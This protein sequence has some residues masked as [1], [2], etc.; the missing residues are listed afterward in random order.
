LTSWQWPALGDFAANAV[1]F[2]FGRF[3][4]VLLYFPTFF[5]CGLWM[6]RADR[7][8]A[9]WLGAAVASCVALQL[10]LPH[11][12]FGGTHALGN[13]LF[14]LLP[15]AL[16][17]VDVVAW[18]PW[19]VALSVA[20]LVLAVPLM[21]SPVYFSLY[22]GR[23]MLEAPY[24]WF[25]LEWRQATSLAF[26]YTFPGLLA[27]TRNQFEWESSGGVWTVGGKRAEFVLVRPTPGPTVVGL[28]SLLPAARVSDG[29]TTRDVHFSPGHEEMFTLTPR[30]VSRD[31]GDGFRD[32]WV[33]HLT[34]ET[35]RGITPA[36]SH[37]SS[38]SR[39]LGVF[40]RPF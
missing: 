35:A 15:V 20:L 31:E 3:S 9:A 30:A 19:R 12:P 40:V 26:P 6:L 36:T 17:L 16:V 7:E 22:P 18:I 24:R 28:S 32:H 14:V 8:K 27:L 25:P 2:V 10:A 37:G 38:D 1:S 33:Y 11:N 34:V 21:Q 4:G 29:S 5:A 23:Q 13:R 39:Y